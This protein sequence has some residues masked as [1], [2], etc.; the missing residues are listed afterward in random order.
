MSSSESRFTLDAKTS[1]LLVIDMQND[2]LDSGGYFALRELDVGRLANREC[3]QGIQKGD[4]W[5]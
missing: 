2:F 3:N 1:A 5:N 4:I